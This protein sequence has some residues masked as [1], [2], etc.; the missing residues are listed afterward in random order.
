M[1]ILR[2][3]LNWCACM[4]WHLGRV[5]SGR[6]HYAGLADTGFTVVSFVL[7][8][9]LGVVLRW[10]LLADL[11]A[12]TVATRWL[13]TLTMALIIGMRRRDQSSTLFCAILAASAVVDLLASAIALIA[14]DPSLTISPLYLVL[15]LALYLRSV[16]V[17]GEQPPSVRSAGYGRPGKE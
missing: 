14:Q 1:F 11:D 17:F 12:Y 9:S 7:V 5:A 8:F 10:G 3:I 13:M 2:F 16:K 6:P 4:L 15:E